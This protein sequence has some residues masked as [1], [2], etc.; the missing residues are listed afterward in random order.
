[1]RAPLLGEGDN[2]IPGKGRQPL[3]P[4]K[5]RE[6]LR[7]GAHAPLVARARGL[8][9]RQHLEQLSEIRV[10]RVEHSVE[11]RSAEQNHL[12][13]DV[14]GLWLEQWP[15]PPTPRVRRE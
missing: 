2:R 9:V 7:V 3:V 4:S 11:R 5:V 12:D 8:E 14:D 10:M 15:C 13:G 6:E 1:M